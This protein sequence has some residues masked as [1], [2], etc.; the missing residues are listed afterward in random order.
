MSI[1]IF[2]ADDHDIVRQG[3][4]S[5]LEAQGDIEIIG[6]ADNGRDTVRR[7]SQL[8]PDIAILD[9]A[10]PELNGLDTA[11]QIHQACPA[12]QIIMLSMHATTE[13][14][15]HA[16][17]VGA[18]GYLLKETAVGEVVDA[19]RAVLVGRLYLSQKISDMMIGDY[20][21]HREVAET[22]TPLSR[23]SGREREVLQLVVEG[24]T[25]AEIADVLAISSR[26]VET[27]RARLME[28]LGL[29]DLPQLVKFAIQHGLTPLQ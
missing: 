10:M 5:L 11:K 19:V 1:T 27:H 8:Q 7:V 28:K 6:E 3:V 13:H 14:I 23:L 17:K 15:F 18:R 22:A 21:N 29:D 24:K 4:R 2:L 12:V 20:I 25:S 9:I 16:L 26:T